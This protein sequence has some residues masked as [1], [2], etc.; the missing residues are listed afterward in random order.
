M[1]ILYLFA[2]PAGLDFWRSSLTVEVQST[3]GAPVYIGTWRTGYW[4]RKLLSQNSNRQVSTS[5]VLKVDSNS[6]TRTEKAVTISHWTSF[7]HGTT[8]Q[9]QDQ[10]LY[11]HSNSQ[12]SLD[13]LPAMSFDGSDRA[14]KRRE[15]P[16][17]THSL[18]ATRFGA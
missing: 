18:V 16:Y 11:T 2:F 14:F 9:Q 8:I 5:T 17:S 1:I 6:P 13:L 4:D 12:R 15:T 7:D 3:Y 10:M